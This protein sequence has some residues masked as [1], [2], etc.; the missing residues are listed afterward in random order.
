MSLRNRSLNR[1]C[2]LELLRAGDKEF[3]V[4]VG[5]TKPSLFHFQ[6]HALEKFYHE[7][8]QTSGS[9]ENSIKQITVQET[10]QNREALKGLYSRQYTPFDFQGTGSTA[11]VL[12]YSITSKRYLSVRGAEVDGKGSRQSKYGKLCIF[13]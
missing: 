5:I 12:I 1:T 6:R 4:I 3:H 7:M 11:R 10:D 9:A 2:P 13:L 8:I